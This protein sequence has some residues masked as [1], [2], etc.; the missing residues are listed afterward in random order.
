MS[1][2]TSS[3]HSF[4]R[5]GFWRGQRCGVEPPACRRTALGV[6]RLEWRN[7][8][9]ITP[10]SA[11]P[12]LAFDLNQG[13]TPPDTQ[14]AVGPTAVAEAVNTNLALFNKSGG[15]LFQDSFETLF[16]NVRVESPFDATLLS[17]PSLHYD[18][19]NGRFVLSIL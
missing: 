3:T 13:A 8:P 15:T 16:S 12:G 7:L 1:R 4:W 10:S 11:F 14:V 19:D 9:S 6:E 2:S 5:R 18:A 17:D